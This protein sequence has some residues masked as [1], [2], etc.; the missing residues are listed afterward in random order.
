MAK[1]QTSNYNVI[2]GIVEEWFHLVKEPKKKGEGF[3]T[4]YVKCTGRHCDLCKED[5]PKVFGKRFYYSISGATWRFLIEPLMEE[6]N[7]YCHCGG[8]IV[9]LNYVCKNCKTVLIHMGDECPGCG[10]E[11]IAID[12]DP[13]SKTAHTASCPK[14]N[15]TWDLL[16]CRDP[17]LSKLATNPQFECPSCGHT[18]FPLLVEACSTEGCEGHPHDIYDCQITIRKKSEERAAH[19]DILS[20]NIQ[21]LDP[22]TFDP[23]FQGGGEYGEK[24]AARNREPIPLDEVSDFVPEPPHVQA[25]VLDLKNP[26]TD[27]SGDDDKSKFS[28]W[29]ASEELPSG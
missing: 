20:W 24:L 15:L 8:Y 5:A 16:E 10:N 6:L 17:E 13:K 22:R 4:N 19:T 26:F 29:T 11:D 28:K 12:A 23:A 2:S 25:K 9:P 21:E 27:K 14:C 18:D 7:R 3:W 1:A